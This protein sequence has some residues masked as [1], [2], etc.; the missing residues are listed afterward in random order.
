[1]LL[2]ALVG[3]GLY[4]LLLVAAGYALGSGVTEVAL[5]IACPTF[6]W[7][8]LLGSVHFRVAPAEQLSTPLP[9][10]PRPANDNIKHRLTR[11]RPRK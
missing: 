1:M 3:I 7:G 8:I 10:V 9:C 5:I 6:V 2:F 11:W 4:S